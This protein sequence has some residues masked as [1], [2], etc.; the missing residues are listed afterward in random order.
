MPLTKNF[1]FQLLLDAAPDL[2][3]SLFIICEGSNGGDNYLLLR[4]Y[5]WE[6]QTD[7]LPGET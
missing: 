6:E 4:H 3:R 2:T 7:S 5:D 1:C